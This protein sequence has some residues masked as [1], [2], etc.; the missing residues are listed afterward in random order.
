MV[1]AQND[2]CRRRALKPQQTNK[3]TNKIYGRYLTIYPSQEIIAYRNVQIPTIKNVTAYGLR[4]IED[5]VSETVL[6]D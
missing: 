3:Q 1:W 6:T 4:T 5:E 2:P